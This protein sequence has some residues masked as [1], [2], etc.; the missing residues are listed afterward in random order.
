MTGEWGASLLITLLI[1]Y[2]DSG[3]KDINKSI[4][5]IVFNIVLMAFDNFCDRAI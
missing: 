4:F 1:R 5:G 2:D 3:V